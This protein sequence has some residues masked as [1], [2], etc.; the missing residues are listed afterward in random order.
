MT[1]WSIPNSRL[2]AVP[3]DEHSS[4]VSSSMMMTNCQNLEVEKFDRKVLTDASSSKLTSFDA[5]SELAAS[6]RRPKFQRRRVLDTA[7]QPSIP[8]FQSNQPMN[9]DQISAT[10]H[11]IAAQDDVDCN[12]TTLHLFL[13]HWNRN[14]PR[15]QN[16]VVFVHLVSKSDGVSCT[17]MET[18]M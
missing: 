7:S 14:G 12:E 9:V 17:K 4:Q 6:Q 2:S 1:H 13:P 11:L 8:S 16:H 10:T 15:V 18:A 3:K 5:R